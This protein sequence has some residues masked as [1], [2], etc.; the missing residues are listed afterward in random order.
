[1]G[2]PE[3][4][5]RGSGGGSARLERGDL[6]CRPLSP[7]KEVAIIPMQPFRSLIETLNGRRRQNQ[8]QAMVEYQDVLERRLQ[9]PLDA[10]DQQ[11]PES[12]YRPREPD[13]GSLGQLAAAGKLPEAKKVPAGAPRPV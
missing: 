2:R 13:I 1:M 11:L 3:S 9:R 8:V 5:R 7:N 6:S 12:G 4:G 10:S